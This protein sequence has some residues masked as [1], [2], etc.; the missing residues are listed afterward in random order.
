VVLVDDHPPGRLAS[1]IE[2]ELNSPDRR[3]EGAKALVTEDGDYVFYSLKPGVYYLTARAAGH[4]SITVR[5]ELHPGGQIRGNPKLV[6]LSEAPLPVISREGEIISRNALRAPR[7]ARKQVEQAEAALRRGDFKQ[8]E[9]AL[10]AALAAY[11]DYA[12]AFFRRAQLSAQQGRTESAEQDYLATVEHDPDY[13][14]AYGALCEIYRLAARYGD[15]LDTAVRWN[16]VQ[17]FD[18]TPHYYSALALYETGDYDRALREAN[19]SEQ[20]PHPNVPHLHLVQA[21]CFLK[22]RELSA[23]AVQL[24]KFLALYPDDP[25]AQQARTTLEEIGRLLQGKRDVSPQAVPVS[26]A[27]R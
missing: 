24:Q 7:Q 13:Y 14:P 17:S 9:E 1:Q 10:Q 18:C 11:P 16:K 15:L 3:G 23:A 19:R 25:L 8:A 5:L 21:N 27:V 20:L 2:V 6:L 22:K 12:R 26:G 4:R